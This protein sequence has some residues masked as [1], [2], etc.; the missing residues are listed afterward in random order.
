MILGRLALSSGI[1]SGR[2]T[3]PVLRGCAVLAGVGAVIVW[4]GSVPQI[5]GLGL[6]LGGLGISGIYPLGASL[7]LAHAP[8]APIR[9][10]ARLTAAS[11]S[12]IFAA[13]LVLGVV[14]GAVGVVGAW[15]LVFGMLGLGLLVLLRIPR[16]ASGSPELAPVASAA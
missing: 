7:A 13:P 12:A 3:L 2:R 8:D 6:F 16:P 4:V 14:A 5:A 1:G 15:L 10:S 11:G 9:A